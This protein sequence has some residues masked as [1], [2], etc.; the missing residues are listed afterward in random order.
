MKLFPNELS[1]PGRGSITRQ[2]FRQFLAC[3][4]LCLHWRTWTFFFGAGKLLFSFL[5]LCRDIHTIQHTFTKRKA[6]LMFQS[7]MG[8][9]S[10]HMH[11]GQDHGEDVMFVFICQIL[12][13]CK[14]DKACFALH[15]QS[16]TMYYALCNQHITLKKW[17][18]PIMRY[19]LVCSLNI[20]IWSRISRNYWNGNLV[21]HKWD[22]W[23]VRGKKNPNTI[24]I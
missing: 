10:V 24:H 3:V 7:L 4:R 16:A 1:A 19:Q 8:A 23:Q 20:Q 2:C 15:L 17:S 13:Q 18:W 21:N 22:S 5:S 6:L 12:F 14:L 11:K 9:C